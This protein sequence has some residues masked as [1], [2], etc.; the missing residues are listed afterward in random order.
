MPLC[1]CA[2]LEETG[3]NVLAMC[4]IRQLTRHPIVVSYIHGE[5][6]KDATAMWPPL[7]FDWDTIGH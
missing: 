3:P 7:G 4:Y 2:F 5:I 1:Y 6:N